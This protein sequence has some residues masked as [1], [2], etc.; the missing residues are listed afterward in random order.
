MG[1]SKAAIARAENV[2]ESAIRQSISRALHHMAVFL[3]DSF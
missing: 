1:M 3:E 2:N